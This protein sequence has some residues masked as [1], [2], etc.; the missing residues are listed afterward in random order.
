MDRQTIMQ[1]E[2]AVVKFCLTNCFGGFSR[3]EDIWQLDAMNSGQFQNYTYKYE[4]SNY[5]RD[6]LTNDPGV[7]DVHK[8]HILDFIGYI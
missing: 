6:D 3:P 1:Y 8:Y 2:R 7:S 5:W 4:G